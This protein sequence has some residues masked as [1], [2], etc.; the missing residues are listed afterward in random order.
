MCSV[1]GS[2]GLFLFLVALLCSV[3]PVRH[4][5]HCCLNLLMVQ[6]C[7][8]CIFI[9]PD[10]PC[11]LSATCFPCQYFLAPGWLF[12]FHGGWLVPLAISLK[13]WERYGVRASVWSALKSV[14]LK[15]GRVSDKGMWM[16]RNR[17]A[18]G[19]GRLGSQLTGAEETKLVMKYG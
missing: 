11:L 6:M 5:Y 9:I 12:D 16:S 17:L 3:E 4:D 7:W 2:S 14:C 8:I 18:G 15:G 1:A 13:M 10:G 19:G